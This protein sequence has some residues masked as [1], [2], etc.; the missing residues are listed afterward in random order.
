MPLN[1][2]DLGDLI[3]MREKL[4]MM[5]EHMLE[6]HTYCGDLPSYYGAAANAV[7]SLQTAVSKLR[8]QLDKEANNA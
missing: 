1:H 7:D 3:T 8:D 2:R 6:E 4:K 5:C